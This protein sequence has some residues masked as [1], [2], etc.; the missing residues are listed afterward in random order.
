MTITIVIINPQTVNE[1]GVWMTS[2]PNAMVLRILKKGQLKVDIGPCRQTIDFSAI[3]AE[4]WVFYRCG[5]GYVFR[6]PTS[7]DELRS[8]TP[9][10]VP[11]VGGGVRIV[12]LWKTFKNCVSLLVSKNRSQKLINAFASEQQSLPVSVFE[13]IFVVPLLLISSWLWLYNKTDEILITPF[14]REK[15]SYNH[16]FF[17]SQCQRFASLSCKCP[18]KSNYYYHY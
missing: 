2:C 11:N 3:G 18:E 6:V 5:V 15:K 4:S 7:E 16:A 12:W 8:K 13:Y 17:F 14:L 10:D 9:R 1:A